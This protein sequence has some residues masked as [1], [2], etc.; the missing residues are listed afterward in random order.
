M[1]S[2]DYFFAFLDGRIS[3][4]DPGSASVAENIREFADGFAIDS[5]VRALSRLHAQCHFL[6]VDDPGNAVVDIW[7]PLADTAKCL[8]VFARSSS[9]Q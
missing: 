2:L 7:A 9:S 6:Q 1:A 4:G 8:E 5:H 3:C